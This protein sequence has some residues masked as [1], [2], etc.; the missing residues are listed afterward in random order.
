MTDSTTQRWLEAW[1]YTQAREGLHRRGDPVP[2]RHA[3]RNEIQEL[4]DPRD[5]IRATAVFDVDGVPTVC[6]I[7]DDGRLADSEESLNRIREKIWNQNLISVA[8]VV[9]PDQALALPAGRKSLKSEHITWNQHEPSGPYSCRGMQTGELFRR[10]KEWFAPD[11]RVDEQLLDDL[12]HI[13]EKLAALGLTK[14]TAQ[15]LMAQVLFISYLEH[16]EI[17]G[18]R[19]REKHGLQRFEHLVETGDRYGIVRLI[20]RLKKDFNGDFLEPEIEGSGLWNLLSGDAFKLLYR[21]LQRENLNGGQRS[22]W[23]YDFRYIPV[24]LLSGIYESFLADDK[25]EVGAYYTPRHLANLA[26]DQAFRHSPDILSERVYDGACGSGIL[27][28]T[29]YRRMLSYA[30]AKAGQP[31]TFKERGQL[32]EGHIFGTDLNKTACRVTAFSLY[33]SMLE[34]LQPADISKLQEDGQVKLPNLSNNNIIGG[35]KYGDFFSRHNPH[36]TSKRF[37][38]LLSNPP[39]VEPTGSQV[40]SSDRWA[41]DNCFKLPRRQTAAAYMLRAR[42]CLVPDGRLCL[43]LPVSVAAATTSGQFISDWLDHYEPETLINFGDLRKLLFSTARQ[44]CM[45]AVGRPRPCDRVGLIPAGETFDYWVPKADISLAFGRLTLH[46]QDRHELSTRFIQMDNE[47]L[48]TLFWGTKR[49]IATISSM[50]MMGRIGDMVGKNGPWSNR[51][52]YHVKDRSISNPISSEPIKN[53]PFLDARKFHVDGPVLDNTLLESFPQDI[54]TVTRLPNALMAAFQGPKIVFTDGISSDRKVRAAFSSET[55]TFKHSIGMLSGPPEDEPLMRF[56][57]A[58][59]HSSLAQYV[60]LMTAYQVNFERERISLKDIQ[61]LPFVHPDRHLDSDRAWAIV[62]EVAEQTKRLQDMEGILQQRPDFKEQDDQ[63]LE[64][65]GLNRL[66]RARV[67]E[68]STHIAPNMQPGTIEALDT[69]LQ[70]RA[71]QDHL[72]A[73]GHSLRDEIRVWSRN[74]GG[75]G[76]V[77]VEVI[78]NS[79]HVCGPLGIVKVTPAYKGQQSKPLQTEMDDKA[80]DTVLQAL[81]E[82][83]LLPLKASS[84]LQ[85]A[86]DTVVRSGD[87]FYLVKPL[88]Q[89]LWLQSEAYRDAERVVRRVVASLDNMEVAG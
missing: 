89:R 8:L 36:S 33:L 6:F 34:G 48:T 12:N 27:L 65:F 61:R 49:D 40:L 80:F 52:G 57:A 88:I 32:L 87:T 21:F 55:F 73:Y 17:V 81:N 42:D 31:L 38:I 74:R 23:R 14:V 75:I 70:K 54:L 26:V 85:L 44:P 62:K 58:Y 37:T 79:R 5:E 15:Y 77:V 76:D 13:V 30:Q 45:I 41:A 56:V 67:Q 3:Y 82:N 18:D 1:G 19:Y 43:I 78:A 25:R 22:F 71:S 2:P 63:I 47:P 46:S 50:R 60:L 7:E 72:L 51:K 29:A 64:Y 39:W 16:R 68:V 35:A 9:N 11:D 83:G 10:H 69:P 4:L 86:P 66:Q 59:L 84:V 20:K 24:E 28:T 53:L